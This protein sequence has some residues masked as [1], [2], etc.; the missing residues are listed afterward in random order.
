MSFSGSY[1]T[2]SG[3]AAEAVSGGNPKPCSRDAKRSARPRAP[4]RVAA[5]RRLPSLGEASPS[6]RLPLA[7][8]PRADRARI[9]LGHRLDVLQPRRVLRRQ[10]QEA[11]LAA[12]AR[13]VGLRLQPAIAA[14][15]QQL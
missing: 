5:T 10:L 13:L 15:G 12:G 4:L 2:A 3:A 1:L 8:A 11:L 7:A 6:I 14:V 9:D